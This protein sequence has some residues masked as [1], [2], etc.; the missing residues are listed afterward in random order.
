MW[1]HFQ[2]HP[3]LWPSY[4]FWVRFLRAIIAQIFL[5]FNRSCK[6]YLSIS[7]SILATSTSIWKIKCWSFQT[8]SLIISMASSIFN[9]RGNPWCSS[10]ATSFQ[11]FMD[12]LCLSKTNAY[13]IT[14]LY[15]SFNS[16]KY[17]VKISANFTRNFRPRWSLIF[18]IVTNPTGWYNTV[19]LKHSSEANQLT[20]RQVQSCLIQVA[21]CSITFHLLPP[22]T[23]F[24]H[25][26]CTVPL[27]NSHTLYILQL[28][29]WYF[30]T[31][32]FFACRDHSN[33]LF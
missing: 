16:W 21:S 26:M 11:P 22:P 8:I 25:R 14:S 33:L 19:T 15:T 12:C 32:I 17:S 18:I 29:Q 6:I 30:N 13:Y 9:V 2:A 27:N 28:L 7:L 1:W 31:T 4:C 10:S 3:V 5:M 24:L 23:S 20:E